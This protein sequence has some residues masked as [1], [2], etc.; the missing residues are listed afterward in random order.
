MREYVTGPE[1]VTRYVGNKF[2]NIIANEMCIYG[3]NERDFFRE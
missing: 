1:Q 2:W 3:K